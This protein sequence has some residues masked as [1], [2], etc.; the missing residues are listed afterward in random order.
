MASVL[1]HMG[2]GFATRFHGF[3]RSTDDLDPSGITE[4]ST[5][6]TKSLQFFDLQAF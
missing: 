4:N 6:A 1:E 2:G 5:I 3:N